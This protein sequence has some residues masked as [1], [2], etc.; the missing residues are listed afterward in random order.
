MSGRLFVN[1]YLICLVGFFA[2]QYS[3][4]AAEVSSGNEEKFKTLA[5]HR[6]FASRLYSDHGKVSD[7]QA[8]P[9]TIALELNHTEELESEIAQIYDSKSPKFHRFMTPNEFRARF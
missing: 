8:V 7:E 6:P 9:V 4:F 3:P 2:I 5:E 1:E